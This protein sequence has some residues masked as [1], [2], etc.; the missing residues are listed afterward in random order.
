MPRLWLFYK[1]F[2]IIQTPEQIVI[3]YEKDHNSRQVRMNANEHPKDFGHSWS[4]HRP[5]G[6]KQA[7]AKS[8]TEQRLAGTN[9]KW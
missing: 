1:S 9:P 4:G 6:W 7:S 5:V 2:E 3:F 8:W